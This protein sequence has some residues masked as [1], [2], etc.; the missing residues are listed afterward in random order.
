MKN[1]RHEQLLEIL[2]QKKEWIPAGELARA[3]GV[4][5]RQ[6]RNYVTA[7]NR[8]AGTVPRIDSSGK[9][10]RLSQRPVLSA[11]DAHSADMPAPILPAQRNAHITTTLL[12]RGN[13][14]CNIF[15]LA[16]ELF[17]SVPTLENDLGKIRKAANGYMLTL[18]R[19]HEMIVLEGAEEQKRCFIRDYLFQETLETA[20]SQ[21]QPF[22][23]PGFCDSRVP[24]AVRRI[25]SEHSIYVNDYTLDD[26]ILRV[27]IAVRRVQCGFYIREIPSMALES[28]NR[29]LYATKDLAE[30]IQST[31]SVNLNSCELYHLELALSDHTSI[32]DLTAITPENLGQYVE[33]AYIDAAR[34]IIAQVKEHYLINSFSDDFFV[35]FTLHL[36]NLFIRSGKNLT[37]K[38][39]LKDKIKWTYPLI[40][41]ISVF[42]ADI[43]DHKYRLRIDEDEIAYI[44]FHLCTCLYGMNQEP[45]TATFI[46]ANYYDYYQKTVELLEKYFDGRLAVKFVVSIHDY[47]P[48][49]CHSDLIISTVGS[50][51]P[52]PSLVINPFPVKQDFDQLQSLI[53]EIRN[54]KQCAFFGRHF[55]RFF[56]RH[57]FIVN[58]EMDTSE[59]L[60]RSMCTHVIG[61]GFAQKRFLEDVLRR[62]HMSDTA[63]NQVAVPHAMSQHVGRSFISVAVN[64][65]PVS[66]SAGAPAVSLVLMIG[67]HQE[68]RRIFSRIFDFLVEILST[69]GNVALLEQAQ[70]FDEF[71]E[72]ICG[73]A[74]NVTWDESDGR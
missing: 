31:F 65:P 28:D 16:E 36:K 55:M 7:I 66:W 54:L 49:A 8:E 60:I 53:D 13:A 29:Y 56:D 2:Y 42:I 18:K 1:G 20:N 48:S 74:G 61:L 23:P 69:A 40:H 33:S 51:L 63:F 71:T 30:F 58:R 73:M 37:A 22:F 4:S 14:G 10:Y 59:E 50:R 26:L 5:T 46:Y 47:L 11:Y 41:D 25:L 12:E 6:I 44:A 35:K 70:T 43:L 15:D 32:L 68:D 67:I 72:L 62:E 45:V 27:L 24:K 34:F 38:N 64:R 21:A 39:P 17:V 3:L 57:C 19:N 9:G 52:K